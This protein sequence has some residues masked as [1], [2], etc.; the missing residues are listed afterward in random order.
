M[1]ASFR[2]FFLDEQESFCQCII[3]CMRVCVTYLQFCCFIF[4][5]VK[6]DLL[7][8]KI[9]LLVYF[10]AWFIP[11]I[12]FALLANSISFYDK[13]LAIPPRTTNLM[14]WL[15]SFNVN[16]LWLCQCPSLTAVTQPARYL[17]VVKLLSWSNW[18]FPLNK[19]WS[20]G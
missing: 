12:P 18:A 9:F 17:S 7:V 14:N 1:V 15:V 20:G 16:V 6:M 19:G 11:T 13:I 4:S 2:F 5:F 10:H 8:C 3:E